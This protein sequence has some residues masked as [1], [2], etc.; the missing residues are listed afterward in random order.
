MLCRRTLLPMMLL[1]P[2]ISI[3]NPGRK[4]LLIRWVTP[5]S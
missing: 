5:M 4:H 3:R 2:T 1:M